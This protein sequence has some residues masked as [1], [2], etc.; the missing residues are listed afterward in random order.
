MKYIKLFEEYSQDFLNEGNISGLESLIGK[1]LTELKNLTRLVIEPEH[2]TM[3]NQLNSMFFPKLDKLKTLIFKNANLSEIPQYA[4]S[5]LLNLENLTFEYN[6]FEKIDDE[7][8]VGIPYLKNLAFVDCDLR[9]DYISSVAFTNIGNLKTLL[10]NS[11]KF[12]ANMLKEIKEFFPKL[13][14]YLS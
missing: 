8:F 5:K 9:G 6:D 10:L 3:F 4:F 13:K 11:C 14:V 2:P 12:D 1:D 7:A